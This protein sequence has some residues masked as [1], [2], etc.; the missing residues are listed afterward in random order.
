M[1]DGVNLECFGATNQLGLVSGGRRVDAVVGELLADLVINLQS[2]LNVPN[3]VPKIDE[4]T[5]VCN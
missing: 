2:K 1:P 4:L 3:H 5:E